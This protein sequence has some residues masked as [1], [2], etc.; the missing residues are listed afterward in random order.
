MFSDSLHCEQYL[1]CIQGKLG[2]GLFRS[3]AGIGMIWIFTF[4]ESSYNLA[5]IQCL[6]IYWIETLI[7]V[8]RCDSSNQELLEI[9]DM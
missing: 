7:W 3:A 2:G 4:M 9:D 6:D 5:S 1:Y 8:W